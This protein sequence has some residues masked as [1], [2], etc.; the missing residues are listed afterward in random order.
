MATQAPIIW[1]DIDHRFIKDAQ[2]TLKKAE[3]VAAVMS[4]ID[5]ILRTRKGERVMLP[6]FGSDLASIIF[7]PINSTTIKFLSRSLKDEIERWDDRVLIQT[8]DIYPDPDTN[9]ISITMMFRIKG[10]AKILKYETVI[11]GEA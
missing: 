8:V 11:K 4:S 5:N 1:S 10:L 6:E 7:E 9:F 3:N 2:G